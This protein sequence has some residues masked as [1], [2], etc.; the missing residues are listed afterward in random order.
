M[1]RK[2]F[3]AICLKGL[4]GGMAVSVLF[5]AEARAQVTTLTGDHHVTADGSEEGDLAL[6]GGLSIG[7]NLLDFG[8]TDSSVSALSW[9]YDEDG[10]TYTLTLSATRDNVSFL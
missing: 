4:L 10:S 2:Y 3:A 7:G 6:D 5:F 1:K 8:T 9:L